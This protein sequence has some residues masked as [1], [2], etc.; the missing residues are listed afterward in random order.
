MDYTKHNA[1][2]FQKHVL[3]HNTES[4]LYGCDFGTERMV[5]TTEPHGRDLI[6]LE[7]EIHCME[8]EAYSSVLKA[9]IVQSDLLTWS[10]EGLMTDLRKELHVTD[11]EHRDLLTKINSDES[12]KMIRQQRN[13][14]FCVKDHV[15]MN[16]LGYT[17][18]SMGN[19][20]QKKLKVSNSA[21]FDPDKYISYGQSSLETVPSSM[22]AL[23][24]D[25]QQ[26]A[27]LAVIYPVNYGK[28]LGAF[29]HD[30]PLPIRT[31]GQVKSQLEKVLHTPEFGN[32]N[33]RS[34]LIE[35]RATDKLICEVESMICNREHP[36]P[37]E[38]E[39]AKIILRD[40]ER[41]LL[42]A[43]AKLANVS[44]RGNGGTW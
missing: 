39:K 17:P 38:I 14:A 16:T 1:M 12:V 20:A 10:K 23:F 33:S 8:T 27:A 2:E 3:V 15:V 41:T 42:E 7:H 11:A 34:D 44:D 18:D 37:V 19:A 35:I 5:F 6:N 28:S 4:P 9:F 36:D 26:N 25:D 13:A 32:L 31:G 30:V 40:H 21:A 43:L 29:N 22:P 24:K